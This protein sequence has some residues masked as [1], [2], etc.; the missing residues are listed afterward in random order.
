M[1]TSKI[2]APN[3]NYT[4]EKSYGWASA[5]ADSEVHLS[6]NA[7]GDYGLPLTATVIG[8]IVCNMTACNAYAYVVNNDLYVRAGF[9]SGAGALVGIRLL[10]TV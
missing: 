6:S 7:K 9:T 10:Y 4:A 3:I 1:A 2:K 8:A 5:S